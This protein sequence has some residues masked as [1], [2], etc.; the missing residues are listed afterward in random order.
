MTPKTILAGAAGLVALTGASAACAETSLLPGLWEAKTT[1]ADSKNVETTRDCIT[2]AETKAG[3]LDAQLAK[4]IRDPSCKYTQ[5][6]VGGGRFAVAATCNNG[7]MKSS[8]RQTGTYTPTTLTM[9]M[10]MTLVAAP[11][12]KPASMAFTSVSRRIAP[13]CPAGSDDE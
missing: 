4:A 5:R 1:F 2:P 6:N 11:G 8:Y 10:A 7:G 12:A 13:T 9:N 3:T